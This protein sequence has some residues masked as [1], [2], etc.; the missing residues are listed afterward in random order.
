M[1]TNTSG[2]RLQTLLDMRLPEIISREERNDSHI[3][4]YSTGDYWAAFECSAYLLSRMYPQ[5]EIN[6]I[7]FNSDSSPIIMASLPFKELKNQSLYD[8]EEAT[9]PSADK[10]SRMEYEQWHISNGD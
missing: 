7:Y 8:E 2:L 3:N 6:P 4:L 9:I 10:L 1:P 5:C